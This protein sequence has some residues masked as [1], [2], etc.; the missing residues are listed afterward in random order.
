MWRARTQSE[1]EVNLGALGCSWSNIRCR[2]RCLKSWGDN[3]H[4]AWRCHNIEPPYALLALCGGDADLT[5]AFL[6]QRAGNVVTFDVSQNKCQVSSLKFLFE[7]RFWA[8]G[9]YKRRNSNSTYITTTQ[10]SVMGNITTHGGL[11]NFFE[12]QM[13]ELCQITYCFLM[14]ITEDLDTFKHWYITEIISW[15]QFLS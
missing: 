3:S 1:I 5:S 2:S 15:N 9:P 7:N 14:V 4:V 12:C 10:I 8:T 11:Y 6:S 13:N